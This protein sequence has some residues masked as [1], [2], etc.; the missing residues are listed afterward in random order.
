MNIALVLSG[1][2]GTRISSD[3]PKQYIRPD[4]INTILYYCLE[5]LFRDKNIDAVQ[6]VADAEYHT[7][8]SEELEQIELSDVKFKGFS[9]PG[10]NRQLSI[11]NGLEDIKAYA[12]ANDYVL[13]HDGARPCLS[14]VMLDICFKEID[15]H[16]GVMPVIPMKD[17]VYLSEDGKSVTS[18]LDRK[19]IF[20]G[21]APELF[22][23][24]KYYDSIEKLLPDRVMTINGS[25]EPAILNGMDVVMIP[26]DENN[27]KITTNADLE[28]FKE[29]L[30]LKNESIRT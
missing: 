13:I 4:G 29:I 5:T 10:K 25:T 11:W 16:D 14:N 18:L 30:R 2:K 28:R 27:F 15:G 20:A 19:S 7:L 22:V 26:G 23:F 21:Q 17:T 9:V 3:I 8:I 1:G 12:D 6:I 24:G